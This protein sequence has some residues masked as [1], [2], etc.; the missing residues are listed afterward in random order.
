[1]QKG[2]LDSYEPVDF[3]NEVDQSSEAIFYFNFELPYGQRDTNQIKNSIRNRDSSSSYS[4]YLKRGDLDDSTTN[5][6]TKNIA[7]TYKY[8]SVD[9]KTE[10]DGTAC[11]TDQKWISFTSEDQRAVSEFRVDDS[12]GELTVEFWFKPA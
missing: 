4:L 9:W 2:L 11:V 10:W 3:L 1:M 12:Y 8:S 7:D 6:L 5:L